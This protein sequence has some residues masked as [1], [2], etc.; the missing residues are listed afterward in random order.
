VCYNGVKPG[1]VNLTDFDDFLAKLNPKTAASFRKASTYELK[2]LET[3]SL[4][5]NLA[6][7]GLGYGRF[8]TFYGNRAGG[9]TMFAL[10]TIAK[11]QAKGDIVAWLDVEKQFSPEWAQKLGVDPDS[12]LLSNNIISIAEM[13]DQAV[14][15][16]LDGVDVLVVDSISQLLP[17]SYF[18]DKGELK[19]LENTGQIGTFSK[20]L[21]SALN[22]MNSVNTKTL[23][24]LIS[25][26]RNQI[27]SYGASIGYMG[28]KALEHANSTVLKFWR[29]PSDVIEKN[30][31][32]GDIILKRPVGA[33][34]TWTAE[35]NRGP[36]MGW[37]N[38]YD[39]YTGGPHVGIDLMS[40]I[41]TFGTEYGV[42]KKGGAWYDYEGLKAQGA[43][44][45]AELLRDNPE[46]AEVIYQEILKKGSA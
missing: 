30:I 8:A 11:A 5:V 32:L 15:L 22:M 46:A 12:M 45:M 25:Q 35:K 18:S 9:K 39:I 23:I 31:H 40:E 20:N 43:D 17:Q 42:I 26:V 21:G 4:G 38:K 13:A 24:I 44:N 33:T 6:I 7:G 3:P 29:T 34:V 10:Q 1:E 41:V 19:D 14:Q 36:G 27:G 37:S 16:I 28:G 2:T